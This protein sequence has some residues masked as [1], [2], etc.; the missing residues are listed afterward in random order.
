MLDAA[1]R[2]ALGPALDGGARRLDRMGLGAGMLTSLGLV[3]GIACS[4]AAALAAWAP[5]LVLWLVNRTLDGL[6]GP[7]ARIRGATDLGGMLDFLSDCVVYAGFPIGV[8]IATSD[9]RIAVCFLLGTYLLNNVA[10]LSFSSILERRRI[11]LGDERSLRFT[12]GLT[13]GTETI[14]CYSLVCVVPDHAGTIFWV[15]GGLVLVTVGQRIL[16]AYRTLGA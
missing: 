4:V 10:L 14:A 6:D 2:S 11:A 12:T 5:A 16:L 9:A 3:L 1:L 7:L 8:A 13:E 15:F